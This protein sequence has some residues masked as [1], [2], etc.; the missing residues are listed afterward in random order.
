MGGGFVVPEPELE[1]DDPEDP[2]PEE[3]GLLLAD[4]V[5]PPQ[6]VNTKSDIPRSATKLKAIRRERRDAGW[7]VERC[8]EASMVLYLE[9]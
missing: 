1:L 6:P 3:A 2:E 9:G 7:C 4:E 5:P 8:Q